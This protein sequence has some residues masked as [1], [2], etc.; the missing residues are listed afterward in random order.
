MVE[1]DEN[2]F[3]DDAAPLEPHLIYQGEILLGVPLVTMRKPL[4]WLL[5]RTG[6]GGPIHEVLGIGETPKTVKVLDSNLTEVKWEKDVGP[7]GD[8]A[9][10][11]LS[12]RPILVLS[13]TCDVQNKDFIQVAPIYPAPPDD[14]YV[15]KLIRNEILSAFRLPRHPP[16]WEGEAFADLEQIQAVHKSYRKVKKGDA[17]YLHFRLRPEKTLKLQQNLTRYFGRPNAFDAGTDKAP[18][19]ATYLCV[20]CFY[21][22]GCITKVDLPENG[23]FKACAKCGGPSWVIQLGSLQQ[24][25]T[26]N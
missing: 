8:Y 4:R 13:Q 6:K 7:D 18:R 19:T 10:A 1:P 24:P 23:D 3:Y 12:K 20:Q 2:S 21:R 14:S 9:M 11:L 25:A 26:H 15:G 5:L 16:D 17:E 22:D